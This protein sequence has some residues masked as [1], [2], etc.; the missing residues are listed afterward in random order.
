MDESAE[1]T[2]PS[3]QTEELI[4]RKNL[5]KVIRTVLQFLVLATAIIFGV[6]SLLSKQ[7]PQAVL[8]GEVLTGPKIANGETAEENRFIAISYPGLTES[9]RLDSKIVNYQVFSQQIE[10]LKASGYV[11]ISQENIIDYYL[12]YGSLP[13]KALFLIFEDGIR[14]TTTLAQKVLEENGYRATVS[15][16]ANNLN[17]I[18]SRFITGSVLLSLSNNGFW[19]TGS[20]G[21]RLSYINVFDRYSN[22]FGHLNANVFLK[23]YKYLW[24]DYDHYLMDFKRD[25]DRLRQ[26]SDAQLIARIRED[27]KLM[28]EAYTN[29]LGFVPGLYIL[30]HSNTGAF[31]TNPVASNANRDNLTSLFT[32]NFNRQ[33]TS[34]NTLDSSIYD[35]S[36][37]Q[38][39]SYFSANHLLMRIQD[40]TGNQMAFITGDEK[41]AEKWY[42]DEGV[43]EYADDRIILTS[44]PR[45]QGHITLKNQLFTDLE[46]TVDLQGN[47]M[48]NQSIYLRADR[49]LQRGLQVAMENNEVVIRE[50]GSVEKEIFRQSLFEFDGGPFVSLQEDEYNGQVAL[51]EA[52]IQFDTDPMRMEEAKAKLA[53]LQSVQPQ[54]LTLGGAPYYPTLDLSDRGSRKLRIRLVGSR[55]SIWVDDQIMVEQLLVSVNLLGSLAFGSEVYYGEELSQRFLYDDVY[56]AVFINPIVRDV[57]NPSNVLFSYVHAQP[58]TI[59]SMIQRWFQ[60]MTNFFINNF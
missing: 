21:Y 1:R 32:M 27:Y 58:E 3:P 14:D 46:M 29:A 6:F 16:Y 34:L 22:Y 38:V 10:A 37:L 15:T 33:G 60:T 13:E 40:D 41:E 19:E 26:E 56:D 39:Q 4:K 36:R 50:L 5:Y 11:T 25:E 17:D 43:A 42:T 49:N 51:Q 20:N 59:N 18:N 57:Q 47:L 31:G 44:Q 12:E 45:G 30:M 2:Q 24:R 54:T 7:K 35:L 55:L 52:L 23:I 28:D 9:K 48:G 8:L 53:Q